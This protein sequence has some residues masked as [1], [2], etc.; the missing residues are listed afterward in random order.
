MRPVSILKASIS[1]ICTQCCFLI[2]DI[3]LNDRITLP[4]KR[5]NMFYDTVDSCLHCIAK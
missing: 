3:T 1:L 4:L 2:K 5:F